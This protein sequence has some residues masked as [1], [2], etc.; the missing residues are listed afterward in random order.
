[1]MIPQVTQMSIENKIINV[2][3]KIGPWLAPIPTA[4]AVG[5]TA[6]RS[7]GWP[8]V[9]AFAAGLAV[10]AGNISAIYT[11]LELRSYNQERRQDDPPAPTWL[12]I[13]MSGITLLAS[14]VLAVMVDVY[15]AIAAWSAAVFPLLSL[16]GAVV[17]ALRGDHAGRLTAITESK[18]RAREERRKRAEERREL[19][20]K[21]TESA[22]ALPESVSDDGKPP[23]GERRKAAWPDLLPEERQAL[24]GKSPAEILALYDI[25]EKSARTWRNRLLEAEGEP[26]V[27]STNGKVRP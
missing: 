10:E 15:P 2:V 12:A 14:F 22:P 3:A 9:V 4:W 8:A 5:I 21:M 18:E 23:E 19:A 13:V 11:A 27:K 7:L 1:M 25:S 20:G 24:T 17:L 16:A 26:K 6:Y